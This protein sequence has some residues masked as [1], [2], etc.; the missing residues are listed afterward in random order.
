MDRTLTALFAAWWA[1]GDHDHALVLADA[2]VEQGALGEGLADLSAVEL[3]DVL[4]NYRRAVL[5]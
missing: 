5:F 4:E 1:T 2:L 3:A